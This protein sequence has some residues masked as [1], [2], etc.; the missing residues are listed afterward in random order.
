MQRVVLGFG[1]SEDDVS[2]Y[3]S[4]GIKREAFYTIST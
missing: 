4:G 1:G 3:P 2:R